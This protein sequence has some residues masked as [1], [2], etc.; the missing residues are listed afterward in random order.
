MPPLMATSTRS[1]LSWS[2]YDFANTIFSAIVLTVYFPLYFTQLSGANWLLGFAATSSMIAAGL[3]TPLLGALSDQTGKTKAYLIR[4]T[5][6]CLFFLIPIAFLKNWGAVMAAFI[7]SCFFYNSALVFYNSLL[8]VVADEKKQGFASGLGTGLGYLGV[9]FALPIAHAVEKQFGTPS[10]FLLAAFL[11]AFFCIPLVLWVPERRVDA[12]VPFRPELWKSEW[13]K[14]QTLISQ[15]P[16]RPVLMCFLCGNFFVVDALN[17]MILW[18]SVYAKE[19]FHPTQGQI[20]QLLMG[21]N[22]SA[23]VAGIASGWLTDKLGAMKTYVFAALFLGVSLVV[24]ASIQSY[25]TFFW[26]SMTGGA[27]CL[28]ATWTCSRKALIELAPPEKIGEYFG[29]LGLITKISVLGNLIFGLVADGAGFRTAL[30]VLVFP[31][32]VGFGFLAG[33]WRLKSRH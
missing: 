3:V 15:L 30:L 21:V 5:L 14:I 12:P 1:L 9:I 24:L 8:P 17:A 22:A 2:L 4:C 25:T 10:V 6:L 26:V 18:F 33:A 11:F 31:A 28:A 32:L 16:D 23:F 27:F 29:V 20:I 19:V 13:K 7:F